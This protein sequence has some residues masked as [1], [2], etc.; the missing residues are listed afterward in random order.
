MKLFKFL[1][2]FVLAIL[3]SSC[4]SDLTELENIGTQTAEV[5]FNDPQNAL[6]GLNSC[7]AAIQDDEY[8][9]YGDIMSDDAVKG[10]SNYF[11]WVDR[12][13]LRSFTANSGNSTSG[14]TWSLMYRT[15]VRCN[16]VIN[17]LPAATFDE[18]LKQRIIAEAKFIRGYAYF[19]LV[20][21]FGGV[22][23]VTKDFTVENLTLPRSSVTDVYA[24]IKVDLDD[25]IANLPKKSEYATSDLGPKEQHKC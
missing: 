8:F 16:D 5:Y 22:P 3:F 4:E 23:L 7:Y 10:G 13:F 15:I 11:D 2:I 24:F 6:T 21:L 9:V 1:S 25:A 19:R 18:D 17:S 20:P 12:E 14:G